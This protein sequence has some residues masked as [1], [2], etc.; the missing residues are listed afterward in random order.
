MTFGEVSRPV[1]QRLLMNVHASDLGVDVLLTQ[2][3]G[4]RNVVVPVAHVVETFQL[5]QVDGWQVA[6][7]EASRV[8]GEIYPQL[9]QVFFPGFLR[10]YWRIIAA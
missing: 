1:L 5:D 10:A 4:D 3:L 7:R 9:A 6:A 8:A 2:G